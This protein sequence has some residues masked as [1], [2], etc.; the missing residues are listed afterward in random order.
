MPDFRNKLKN[1]ARKERANLP[2]QTSIPLSAAL[3]K[4]LREH[5]TENNY[6]LNFKYYNHNQCELRTV[7]SFKPLIDKFNYMT[8]S[9]YVSFRSRGRVDNRGDYANLFIGLPADIDLEEVEFASPGRIMF[10][11]VE[12]YICLVSVLTTHRRT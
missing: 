3:V 7:S 11:R 2:Q 5:A 4:T 10:F 6:R 12:N 1:I 9:N 8:Q